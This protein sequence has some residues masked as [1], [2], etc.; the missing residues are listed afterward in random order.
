MK[1]TIAPQV[2]ALISTTAALCAA[3]VLLPG[4]KE[5]AHDREGHAETHGTREHTESVTFKEGQGLRFAPETAKHIG[6]RVEEVTEQTIAEIIS[7][8]ADVYRTA[9]AAQ[10]AS[11]EPAVPTVSLASALVPFAAAQQLQRGSPVTVETSEGVLNG[12]IADAHPAGANHEVIIAITDEER[13]LALGTRVAVTVRTG[14]E[15][16]FAAVPAGALLRTLEG[17]FVYTLSGDRF[18]RTAVQTGATAKGFVEI[19]D[20]L[21][22]GDQVVVNPVMTLWLA[23]LQV[24]RGGKACADGD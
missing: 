16:K 6:L 20:G 8:P 12:R 5:E 19:I 14:E 10:V 4:C 21:Y 13:R 15:K 3:G 7:F 17:T 23:E 11:L 22:A 9:A 1:T 24:V 2:F 18:I